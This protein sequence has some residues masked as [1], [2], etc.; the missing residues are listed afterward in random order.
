MKCSVCKIKEAAR[1]RTVCYACRNRQYR[2]NNPMR[3]A[4]QNLKD[5]AKRRGHDFDLTFE[6]FTQFAIKTDYIIKKGKQVDSY[7]IDRKEND[8]GYTIGNIQIL[9]LSENSR[10]ATKKVVYDWEARE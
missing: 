3:A 7:S 9:T 8:K 10:K 2:L 1:Q 4:Y 6:Q 5:N